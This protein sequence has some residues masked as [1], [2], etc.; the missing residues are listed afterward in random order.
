[1]IGGTV[2][3]RLE[4]EAFL[5]LAEE[6]H[7][8]RT[9]E[10][11][12]LTTGR[13]SQTIKKL[14]RRV[15]TAL[16]ERTSR[17]VRLTE[18]GQQLHDDLLP[19]CRQIEAA[20][21]RA[22]HTA[23]GVDSVLRVGFVGAA[24]GQLVFETAQLYARRNPGSRILPRELQIIDAFPRL[25][26]GDVEVLIVSLPHQEPGM[27][28]GPVLFSEPRMLAVSSRHPLAGRRAVSLEDLAAVR[29][30]QAA[31]TVPDY[32]RTARTPLLTPAGKPI[33][34]GPEFGTFHEALLL[35]GAGQGAFVVGA[36]AVRYYSRSDVTYIPFSDA[37]PLEWISTWLASPTPATTARILS[38]NRA[39]QDV[40]TRIHLTADT[41]PLDGAVP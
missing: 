28:N 41:S 39:A 20:L 32:W 36:Q 16:F 21:E 4:L 3:E 2:L 33:E 8:G 5:T 26:D 15:G 31:R 24:S 19:A 38:F 11:L 17:Q 12:H 40:V 23:R 9:A 34:R 22:I 25:H 27:V 6:L 1:M 13:I 30:L 18:A 10:R 35:I 29:L 37:P 7:F 14:E